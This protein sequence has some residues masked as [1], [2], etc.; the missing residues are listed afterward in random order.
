MSV[1]RSP[2]DSTLAAERSTT[3]DSVLIVMVDVA[4]MNLGKTTAA[5]MVKAS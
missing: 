5:G 1:T 2:E 3:K 4:T